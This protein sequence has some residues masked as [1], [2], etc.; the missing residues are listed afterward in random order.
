MH[1]KR[2]SR[3]FFF[4]LAVFFIATAPLIVFYSFGYRYSL[5]KGIFIYGGSI[6]IKSNPQTVNIMIDNGSVS[7]RRVSFINNYYHIDGI[8]PGVHQISVSVDGYATWKKTAEVHSGISTEFW[9][10]LLT[11]N[12]YPE[13]PITDNETGRF[14]PSP[15]NDFIAL[16]HQSDSSFSV[17]LFDIGNKSDEEYFSSSTYQLTSNKKENIEWAPQEN[18][19]LIP[20]E[21]DGEKNY[22]IVNIKDKSASKLTDLAKMNDI[23]NVRWDSNRKNFI[24]FQSRDNLYQMDTEQPAE[25]ALVSEHISDYDL[26][27]SQIY[28][29]RNDSGI[30]YRLSN[31]NFN[32]SNQITTSPPEEMANPDYQITVYDEKR[33][34]MINNKT[35]DLFIYNEGDDDTYFREL[36]NNIEDIQFSNDGKKL[37]YW[38]DQEIFAYFNRVWEV[39]PV[40][41]E[42]ESLN[43]TRYS[44]KINNVQWSKDYEHIIFSVGNYLKV[45]ELDHRDRH[46]IMDVLTNLDEDSNAVADFSNNQ[47]YISGKADDPKILYYIKFPDSTGLFGG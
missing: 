30:I 44:Q 40:R 15:K 27:G 3:L 20:V 21:K 16:T 22:F 32:D 39:Q 17:S 6:T 29:F 24:Y 19:L 25:L 36:G 43:I 2:T 7:Q 1:S 35:K 5:D 14:F 10:V 41:K 12:S 9:N 46:I 31:S 4:C 37:L 47:I 33:I 34:A 42:N 11:R 45:A 18:K 8:R 38:S 13:T 28:I 23:H 26:S